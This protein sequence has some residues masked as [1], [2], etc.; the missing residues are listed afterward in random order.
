[1][2]R[3]VK[4]LGGVLAKEK[5]ESYEWWNEAIVGLENHVAIK[6]LGFDELGSSISKA[7]PPKWL[8]KWMLPK[9][10]HEETGKLRSNKEFMAYWLCYLAHRNNRKANFKTSGGVHTELLKMSRLAAK[11]ANGYDIPKWAARMCL[12]STQK[13]WIGLPKEDWTTAK[14][15]P[16]LLVSATHARVDEATVNFVPLPVVPKREIRPVSRDDIEN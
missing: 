4:S 16:P 7:R 13:G 3:E 11:M 1:M 10:D 6:K 12:L 9:A 5:K 2:N 15:L 8:K 14:T